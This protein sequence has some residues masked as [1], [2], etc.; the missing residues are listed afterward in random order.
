MKTLKITIGASI[1]LLWGS[2]LPAQHTATRG[3]IVFDYLGQTPPGDEPEVFAKGTVS[4]DGKNTHAVQFSPDGKRFHYLRDQARDARLPAREPTA[5]VSAEAIAKTRPPALDVTYIANEGFLVRAA[6]KKVLTDAPIVAPPEANPKETVKAITGG[7]E[8]F[9]DLDLILVTHQHADHFDPASLIACLRSNSKARLVAPTQAVDLM[10]SIDGFA[11]VESQLQEIKGEA[12]AREQVRH[13]GITV[14]V[15]CLNHEH[16]QQVRN[17]AFVVELGGTRFLHMGDAFV[18][19]NEA[20]L[21]SYPFEQAPIDFVFLNQYDRSQ[22]TQQF[23][24]RKIKP[25]RIIAMHVSPAELAEESKKPKIR[26]AYPYAI[27]FKQSMERRS[28]QI[29]V[30]FHNLSGDYFGQPPP[31]ATP[32]VF[33]RGIVSTDDLEHSA[34]SFS[35]DGN[36]VYWIAARPPGPDSNE[37]LSWIM[38]MRR[39]NGRWSAPYVAAFEAMP[40]LS[41]DGRRAYFSSARPRSGTTQESQPDIWFVERQGNDWSE[42]KCLNLVARYPELR[43]ARVGAIARNGTLYFEAYVPGPLN[44]YGIYRA[45]LVTGE[46]VKP[47]LLPRSINLPPFLNW[48]PFIAPDESY[49][50]FSSNRRD[51]GHDAGD[52]YIS[53]RLADSSWTEPVSLGEPIN[54]ERQERFPMVSRD[55]RYLFFTRPTPGHDQDVY[56]VDAAT[57]AALRPMTKLPQENPK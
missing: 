12:G 1:L 2:G 53:R 24:A 17:L 8:P 44:D 4:V 25:S 6:G 9:N 14:D 16:L 39:E 33:A 56:W 19:E 28:L 13:N 43:W 38:T 15:L 22:T 47:Q 26:A 20:H 51:P 32:Q 41:A 54:S 29:E 5:E 57:I 7:R 55:G 42:P 18:N 27:V 35:A 40:V 10:R 49:L 3:G 46:Y 23:I 36:E 45:E 30:D 31:G 50:L 48:T 52:L 21:Q 11:S 37:W 34:P